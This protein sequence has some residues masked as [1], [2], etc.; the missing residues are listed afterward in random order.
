[1]KEKLTIHP[2]VKLGGSPCPGCGEWLDAATGLNE[3]VPEPG[4]GSIC[5]YCGTLAIFGDDLALSPWPSALPVPDHV[6][7]LQRAIKERL[8]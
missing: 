6:E 4:A 8:S 7:R 3:P 5:A 1:M 2:A